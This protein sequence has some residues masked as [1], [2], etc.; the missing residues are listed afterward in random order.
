MSDLLF[1]FEQS[2]LTVAAI[3]G[4]L[5]AE[6]KRVDLFGVLVLALDHCC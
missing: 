5:A 2:G 6:N 4:V 3:S 1:I